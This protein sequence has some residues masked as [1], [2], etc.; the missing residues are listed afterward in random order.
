MGSGVVGIRGG[1]DQGWWGSGG[2][3]GGR[4]VGVGDQGAVGVRE[5]WL[6]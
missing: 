5:W 4:V 6:W 1:G 3:G 2:G